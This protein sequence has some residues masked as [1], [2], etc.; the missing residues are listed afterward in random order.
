MCCSGKLNKTAAERCRKICR[1]NKFA[2]LDD[3][4]YPG[5]RLYSSSP[6]RLTAW[7]S[8]KMVS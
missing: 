3:F 1:K 7:I 4:G 8:F 5:Y 2:F 6:G